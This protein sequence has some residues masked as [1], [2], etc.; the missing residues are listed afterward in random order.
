VDRY[1][2]LANS[3]VGQAVLPRLGLPTPPVLRRYAPGQPL[4]N[5]PVLLGAAPGGSLTGAVRGVLT[6][7]GCDV[8]DADDGSTRWGAL[9]LDATGITRPDD[10]VGLHRFF[11]PVLRRL[12]RSGRVLVVGRPVTAAADPEDAAAQRAL[13]GFTRSVGKEVG[14]R[15]STAQLV[16][17]AEGAQGR[18]ASTLRFL[19]SARSAFVSGQVIE[20]GTDVAGPVT[21]EDWDRPLAGQVV[22]VTGASRGIGEAIAAT[23]ARD[24]AT[25]V[26]VDVP[27]AASGLAAVARTTGG[28]W[29]A[30]DVTAPD[31]AA[32]LARHAREHHGG[33]HA[34]VHNAG[35]TRDRRLVNLREDAWRQVIEV[36]LTAPLRITA[37]LVKDGVL[38]EGGRVVGVSSVAGIAG[39]NGQTNY[40]ASKAGVIGLV[41]RMS[42]DLAARGITVNAVA[43]GFIETQMTA[44]VPLGIREAGRRLSSLLQGG[45]PVDV[46]E[47][48]AWLAAPATSGV[49]GAV[50][51]VCGQAVLGA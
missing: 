30:V 18:L 39:N 15:G 45:Q 35:I 8:R 14:N 50:V 38:G 13:E 17:V 9:V 4:T 26:A 40:A 37:E 32:R 3:S 51:R 44:K 24:G 34:V 27:A 16:W 46:A 36:N 21:V 28:S 7:A 43:P 23:T 48:V 2:A 25:V 31:A 10:L 20:V 49:T 1:A 5:G 22:V 42:A 6:E 19:L 41:E 47:T 11:S 33:L 29:L 12:A